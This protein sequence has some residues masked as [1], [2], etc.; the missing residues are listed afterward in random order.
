MREIMITEHVFNSAHYLP[1]HPKCGAIHGHTYYVRNVKIQ[2]DEM[3][4]FVDFGEVKKIIADW[5]HKLIIPVGHLKVWMEVIAPT[6]KS[7]GIILVV[8]TTEGPPS[9]EVMSEAIAKEIKAMRGVYSVTL[10]V[11]EGPIQGGLGIA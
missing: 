9:V 6:L 4:A 5:D 7:L 3:D 10:E 1:D 2:Y 8:K 11:Y